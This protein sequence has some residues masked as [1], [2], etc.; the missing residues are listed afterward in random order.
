MAIRV[1][2]ADHE[3]CLVAGVKE[4]LKGTEIEL[5]AW[6]AQSNLV[7]A[8][9]V[10][11]RPDVILLSMQLNR[12]EGISALEEI[13]QSVPEIPVLMLASLDHPS[14]MARAYL[15]GAAGCL[16][17]DFSRQGLC[18]AIRTAAAGKTL[19]SR[20]E[21][22][23][24]YGVLTM[25][26]LDVV[27]DVPITPRE[28]EVL[29]RIAQG[30]TNVRIAADLSISHDTVKEHVQHLLRKIGLQDRTQAALWAVRQG[31]V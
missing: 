1:L 4:L 22:R 23:R 11:H 18:D 2:V 14:Q 9:T 15:A 3:P 16:L 10:E 5:A 13:R 28:A 12:T 24:I 26:R 6:A 17:K 20:D 7:L 21:L 19:W 8:L 30:H 29:R 31:L 25:P 27:L